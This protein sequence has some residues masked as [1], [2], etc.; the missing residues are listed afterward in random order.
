M[1]TLVISIL[2]SCLILISCAFKNYQKRSPQV[3]YSSKDF[4]IPGMPAKKIRNVSRN[5]YGFS[6][7]LTIKY[8]D[9]AKE[10]VLKKNIW[11]YSDSDSIA[12]RYYDKYFYEIYAVEP[13]IVYIQTGRWTNVFFSKTLDS[14]IYKYNKRNLKKYLDEATYQKVLE[15]KRLSRKL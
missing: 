11:G 1:K 10:K 2:I 15:N 9:G 3:F 4:S 12:Y 8:A 13:I 7:H 14:D 5:L 6:N